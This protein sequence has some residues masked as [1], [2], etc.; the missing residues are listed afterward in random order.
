MGESF[1]ENK[2]WTDS[3]WEEKLLEFFFV[4]QVLVL[5][6]L[7][8]LVGL[9]NPLEHFFFAQADLW[10]CW[11]YFL[12]GL[13]CGRFLGSA[14]R[15]WGALCDVEAAF[16]AGLSFYYGFIIIRGG[17]RLRFS[18]FYNPEA[19]EY[20][21]QNYKEDQNQPKIGIEPITRW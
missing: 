16:G 3:P 11:L 9:L 4:S 18:T 5:T 17:N 13:G 8:V 15:A 10:W 7:S 2:D 20:C 21:Y 6:H 19:K 14:E 12:R 1:A